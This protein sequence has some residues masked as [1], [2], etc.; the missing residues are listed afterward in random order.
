VL[1]HLLEVNIFLSLYSCIC[2]RLNLIVTSGYWYH[3]IVMFMALLAL[4]KSHS[5]VGSGGWL[6][7]LFSVHSLSVRCGQQIINI[8][9]SKD[10]V[11]CSALTL[12]VW[13]QEGLLACKKTEW[14]DAGMVTCL[15]RG[16]D[17]HIAS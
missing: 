16:A 3:Q 13:Q 9:C 17:L 11:N 2:I 6:V 10:I 5:L 8:K 7:T 4:E 15:G 1:C 14:W 12:L